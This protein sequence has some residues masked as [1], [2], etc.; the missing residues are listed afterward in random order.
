M[1]VRETIAAADIIRAAQGGLRVA[2]VQTNG[3]PVFGTARSIGTETGAFARDKDD[4]LD[5]Y[6]RVTSRSGWEHFWLVSEL[7][8]EWHQG[9]FLVDVEFRD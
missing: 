3:D 1:N 9:L 8:T 2:R 4:V 7:I 5:S 6:L